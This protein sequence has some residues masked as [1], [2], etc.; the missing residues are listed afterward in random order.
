M[1]KLVLKKHNGG[2]VAAD[3]LSE[4]WLF[5]ISDG[6]RVMVDVRKPRHLKH[7]CK[8]FAMLNKVC[9]NIDNPKDPRVLLAYIQQVT[10]LHC[11]IIHS[12]VHGTQK[13]PKSIAFYNMDQ[14]EFN[15]FYDAVVD[16]IVAHVIPGLDKESLERE[17]ME[18]V[19]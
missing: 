17:V 5:K 12:T 6:D 8:M 14:L 19:N 4:S 7:H 2:L 15:P 9:E 13:I 3:E 11:N 18:M 16:F 1:P 10:G